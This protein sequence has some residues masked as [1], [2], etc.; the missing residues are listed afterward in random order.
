M[1]KTIKVYLDSETQNKLR[2]QSLEL[3][4]DGRAWLTHY[5]ERIS[6]QELIFLDSNV[7]KLL[8][9]IDLK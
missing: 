8:K 2:Q 6:H 9:A 4:I 1:K 7:K 3:G 5:L